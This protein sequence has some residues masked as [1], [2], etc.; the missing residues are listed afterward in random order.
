MD[1]SEHVLAV[2]CQVEKPTVGSID[3]KPQFVLICNRTEALNRV[4]C[5]GICGS[6]VAAYEKRNE[7]VASIL[8][9]LLFEGVGTDP[10]GLV[11]RYSSEICE[12]KAG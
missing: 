2:F 12:R 5:A 8:F 1:A 3:V 10:V 7:A 11:R 6:P 9:D 4:Y